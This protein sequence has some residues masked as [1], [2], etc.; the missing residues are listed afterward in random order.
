MSHSGYFSLTTQEQLLYHRKSLN[1][2]ALKTRQKRNQ[3]QQGRIQKSD[4]GGGGGVSMAV[5]TFLP[6]PPHQVKEMP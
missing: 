6:P 1:K 5:E 3:W 2:Y 4:W